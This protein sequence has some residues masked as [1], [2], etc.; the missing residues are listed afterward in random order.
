MKDWRVHVFAVWKD[1]SCCF[2]LLF[3]I[4]E[5]KQAAR[6]FFLPLSLSLSLSVCVCVLLSLSLSLSL[7]LHISFG[8]SLHLCSTLASWHHLHTTTGSPLLWCWCCWLLVVFFLLLLFCCILHKKNTH[9]EMSQNRV[10]TE[11]EQKQNR[12][13]TET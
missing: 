4:L 5:V 11:T 10:R 12:D 3:S 2:L 9:A 1:R 13:K 8:A 6:S 7:S